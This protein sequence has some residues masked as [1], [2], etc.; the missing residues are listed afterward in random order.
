MN[1]HEHIK[2]Q[3][4]SRITIVS[5]DGVEFEKYD[6]YENGVEL[7]LQDEGRTLKIFPGMVE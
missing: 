3:D 6:L 7:S 5:D 4:V 2:F 1:W